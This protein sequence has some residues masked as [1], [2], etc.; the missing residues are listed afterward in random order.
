VYTTSLPPSHTFSC[1]CYLVEAD[2]NG[3]ALKGAAYSFDFATLNTQSMACTG[4]RVYLTGNV[5]SKA[6]F[7]G[8]VL[9][10]NPVNA[11]NYV[12][13]YTDSA[14]IISGISYYDLNSNATFDAGDVPC[15]TKLKLTKGSNSLTTMIN[16][17][18]KIGVDK[19]TYISSIIDAP[20]YYTYTPATYTSAFSNLTNQIDSLNDFAFQPI[21][22]QND[23]V[24]DLVLGQ[25]RPGFTGIAHAT[26]KNI[27]TTPKSGTISLVINHPDLAISSCIPAA[28]S[29]TG[30]NATLA[31]NL[32][33]TEQ[34]SYII[35]Y[36]VA[37]SA[38]LGSAV[39]AYASAPDI[40][41]ITPANNS[42][43]IHTL[44][45]GSFD[46]N[47]KDVYPRGNISPAF[48]S[49]G[50]PLEYT[51][52]FQNTGNDTAF[53]VIL[54]DTLSQK[55]DPNSFQLISASH[56][57]TVDLSG[58]MIWFRFYHIN[59]VDSLHNEP[60]SHGYVK[61]SIKPKSSCVLGDIITN[62]AYIYFD[63]NTPIVTNTASTLIDNGLYVG[64]NSDNN[65]FSIFPNPANTSLQIR[66]NSNG[67]HFIRIYDLQGKL[68]L[69]QSFITPNSVV[70]IIQL[71]VGA[72]FVVLTDEKDNVA[73]RFIKID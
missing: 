9:T 65:I 34:I 37:V 19:G 8:Y 2:L 5:G 36:T 70:D 71:P 28:L 41:D 10:S 50:D 61:Y 15:D 20:L 1:I 21:A 33:P 7:G 32:N 23:L 4:S 3:N 47:S 25:L 13:Q 27:G 38:P 53:T 14:N 63:Y 59:L 48:I 43:T 12:A 73:K 67:N 56:H 18:Y 44:I 52:H 51:I 17:Q 66:T 72:Y 49:H 64:E 68:W 39:L 22:G 40:T 29:I 62:K 31:Y 42:D 24:I 54:A 35:E 58:N 6:A 11:S 30:N 60:L 69:E 26:L 57:V 45:T 16:G 55:L 46:P